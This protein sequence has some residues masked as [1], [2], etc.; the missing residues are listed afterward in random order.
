MAKHEQLSNE[1]RYDLPFNEIRQKLVLKANL[2]D[3]SSQ[4]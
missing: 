2:N 1:I 4:V 3:N